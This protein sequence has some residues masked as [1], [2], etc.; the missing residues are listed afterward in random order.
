MRPPAACAHAA[1]PATIGLVEE[2]A[3][4]LLPSL[5]GVEVLPVDDHEALNRNQRVFLY[6][7][8]VVLEQLHSGRLGG[9]L[10]D[11]PPAVGVHLDELDA[12]R[13]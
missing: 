3:R 5:V 6:L 1:S 12:S 8:V 9:E 11:E 7:R 13:I 4:V 10:R 2:S